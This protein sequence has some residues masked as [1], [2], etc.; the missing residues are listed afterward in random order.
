MKAILN[1]N[2]LAIVYKQGWYV[3][4]IYILH[5]IQIDRSVENFKIVQKGKNS[6]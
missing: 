6:G 5:K 2:T 1:C 3:T 4:Y